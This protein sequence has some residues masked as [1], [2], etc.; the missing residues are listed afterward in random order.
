[1]DTLFL[2]LRLALRK[3]LR[4][5]GFTIVSIATLALAIGATTAIFSVLNG[6][7]FKPLPFAE[8]AELVHISSFAHD[9]PNPMSVLDFIDYRDQTKSFAG[10]SP[11][12][13]SSLNLTGDGQPLRVQ[14]AR[15]G[16]NFFDVLGVPMQR[17][18][19][20][21][22]GED[23]QNA[24]AVVIVSDG[25][26]RSRLGA[27]PALIGRTIAI[28]GK[29]HTVV[30]VAPPGLKYPFKA[31]IWVPFVW[32]P[33]EI[34]PGNR[35][36]H[37]MQ[38]I[39]RLEPGVSVERAHEEL[40][41]LGKRLAA[42][43]PETNAAFGGLARPLQAQIVGDV[44]PALFAMLGAVTF[45]L[46]IACANIANL[47]LVR[48]AGREADIAVRT[49]LG[50]SRRRLM[51]QLMTESVLLSLMGAAA[52]CML[53]SF[54]VKAVVAFGPAALPRL[55]E[56]TID[57]RVLLF[58]A[59]V[60]LLT[61]I[62]FGFAPA[63]Y[64]ARA[65]LGDMLRRNMRGSSRGGAGRM[66]NAL[67]ATEIALAVVLLVGAGLLIR[68]FERLTRVDPGFNAERVV[69]FSVT[70]PTL[71]YP[72]DRHVR[73]FASDV[74]DRLRVLP[75]TQDVGIT[76]TRPM[77]SGR[78]RT[79]FET[80]GRPEST[81][82][83]ETLTQVF[84]ASPGFFSALQIPLIRGRLYTRAED[85]LGVP[86]VVV[87]NQEFAR[88][89][90]PNGDAIGKRITL[91]IT[92]DTADV[93]GSVTAGGEIVGIVA[94]VKDAGLAAEVFP[95]TYIPF[96]TLPITDMAFLI[97][98]TADVAAIQNAIRAQVREV[99]ADVPIYDLTTM[100]QV[101]SDNVGQPRFYA[102]LLGSF[103]MIAL[104]LAALGIYGVISYAVSQRSRELGI[105][106][107][108]GA[109]GDRIVRLV[110][111]QGLAPTILGVVA[112]LMAAVWLTRVI[113]SL[114]FGVSPLDLLTLATVPALLMGVAVLACWIPARR[115][116]RVDPVIAMRVE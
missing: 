22:K 9:K 24:P 11:M 115:A 63:L 95:G 85:R 12:E 54:A 104:L 59:V 113:S 29:P 93:P 48:A 60:G 67:V 107:A 86:G 50:A 16:A 99:D 47:L 66:R 71:K 10:M 114:L 23:A 72:Q 90:F 3:L 18:R 13:N 42:Q 87:V 34:D 92:H 65:N 111:A 27:D 69:A 21:A 5:P 96:N 7:L 98:S 89:Y 101:L 79:S 61:G 88:R 28:D 6:V 64:T 76:F 70:L 106:I 25:I 14:G 43:Y 51:R 26:W 46:L 109:T 1:M 103:A 77:G 91:G 38:A 40:A 52:G 80:E 2:D 32:Q 74:A 82:G 94:N 4:A 17:G 116:A 41:A 39:A 68:S 8:P 56:I 58:T 19:A 108:I 15:V 36:A 110:L 55:D 81:P 100:N 20:F 35:G 75:G 105:R 84:P 30:G 53:A 97:R 73:A 102:L 78:M 57:T 49:A 112:G 44:R 45:V 31:E 37:S 62:I 83:N 33:W